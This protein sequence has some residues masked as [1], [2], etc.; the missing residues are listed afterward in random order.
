MTA[1][2]L[3]TLL[4]CG[5]V[6]GMA[7]SGPIGRSGPTFMC[8]Y[9]LAFICLAGMVRFFPTE[10]S[11]QRALWAILGFGILLRALFVCFPPSFDVHRYVWEGYIQARGFNPYLVA[12]ADPS[13]APLASGTMGQ[14]WEG[15]NHKEFTACY[16]PLSML[17][18]RLLA[19]VWPHPLFFKVVMATL[20]AV[21]VLPLAGILKQRG[22]P[23]ARL[24]WYA[25]NPLLLVFIAGEGHLD[26]LM[27]FWLCLGVALVLKGR[28]GLGFFCIGCA[29]MAKY[30]ACLALPFLLSCDN[31]KKSGFVMLP[32]LLFLPFLDAGSGL[33]HSVSAFGMELHYNDSVTA[34]LRMISGADTVWAAALILMLSLVFIFLTVHDRLR[35]LLFAFGALLVCLPTLHPWYLSLVAPFAAAFASPAWLFLQAAAVF[36]FPVLITEYYTGVFQEIHWLKILEYFPFCALLAWSLFRGG[37]NLGRRFSRVKTVSVVIP[38][39][40]EAENIRQCLTSLSDQSGVSQVIVADGGSRDGTRVIAERCG[41][42]VARAPRGRGGQIREGIKMAAGDMILIL[43]ADCRLSAGTARRIVETLNR[44]PLLA[45]GA[46]AMAF[47]PGGGRKRVIAFLNNLRTRLTGIAFGDQG[48]F[49]RAEVLPLIGGFPVQMLME[50]VELSLRLKSVGRL[51]FLSGGTA[52]SGRRWENRPFAANVVTVLRLFTR[53]LFDRRLGRTDHGARDFYGRYYGTPPEE[54]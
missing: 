30:F 36:T 19:M 44:D 24:L 42:D 23:I 41:A 48:Q 10:L 47:E 16:P 14:I 27:V 11:R 12:P 49:F 29:A 1:F 43:H 45:G 7:V 18:F 8:L 38:T 9:A 53:Y 20:D 39:L 40:N 50:D 25:A 51:A 2:L 22:L 26:S 34:I 5:S 33:F 32:A 21:A 4:F 6:W 35:S 52:V 17:L 46:S 28:A 37:A 3:S 15:I 31:W 54:F 13:L